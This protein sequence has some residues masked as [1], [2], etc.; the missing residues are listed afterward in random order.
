RRGVCCVCSWWFRIRAIRGRPVWHPVLI[1]SSV[2]FLLPAWSG[3]FMPETIGVSMTVMPDFPARGS[4]EWRDELKTY[5]DAVGFSPAVSRMPEF[6]GEGQVWFVPRAGVAGIDF[7]ADTLDGF[8]VLDGDS[9]T[10]SVRSDSNPFLSG[11]HL[12]AVSSSPAGS[13]LWDEFD[14]FEDGEVLTL[15]KTMAYSGMT[16]A[17][18]MRFSMG[19]NGRNC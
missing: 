18:G 11:N 1:S 9:E 19:S 5:V 8:T 4:M 12:R 2:P 17:V 15:A 16:A 13:L 7:S 6:V 10:W 14:S 3:F